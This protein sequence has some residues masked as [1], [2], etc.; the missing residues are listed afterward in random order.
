MQCVTPIPLRKQ[1]IV[2]PCGKCNAC[3][4]R[5][6]ADWCIR[7]H[8]ELKACNG[9]AVFST[10]TYSDENLPLADDEPTLVKA[11]FQ[12]FMKRLRK[13]NP[14]PIRYYCVGEYGTKFG[15]PHYHALIFGADKSIVESM[16]AEWKLGNVH[17]GSV[18]SATIEYVTKYVINRHSEKKGVRT[19]PFLLCLGVRA[20]APGISQ[21]DYS[22]T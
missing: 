9:M 1:E 18:N 6:R 8:Y 11:D 17:N 2:V 3:L 12:N 16:S 20:S 7:L 5:K 13:A 15:R 10:L 22:I 19:P 4:Q 21:P 14:T